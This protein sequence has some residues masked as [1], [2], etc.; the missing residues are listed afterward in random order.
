MTRHDLSKNADIKTQILG[1]GVSSRSLTKV[2]IE[3]DNQI[4][5]NL[6][7]PYLI[8]T[9]NPEFIMLAQ[10]DAEFKQILNAADLAVADGVGLKLA[11]QNIKITPG[12]KIV[13]AVAECGK[14]KIFYL[15]AGPLISEK[16][17]QKYGGEA[18]MGEKD[19]KSGERETDRIIEKIN[20]YQPDILL[21]AYGAPFQEK[22]LWHHLHELNAKVMM[23]VGGSFDYLVGTSA[24]PPVII[25]KLGLEW[26]WRLLHQ[27]KRWKRQLT[28]IKFVI[29]VLTSF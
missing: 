20:K 9:I 5:K 22:W 2:L 12:R 4:S 19:I 26:L 17:A 6:R 25:E 28:L 27:P 18:D 11:D 24:L 21:V 15:G 13:K 8:T 1:V 23:G 16:M 10:K 14:Y 29:K 3:I 7:Q